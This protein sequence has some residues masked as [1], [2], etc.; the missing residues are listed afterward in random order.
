M[1]TQGTWDADAQISMLAAERNQTIVEIRN[2]LRRRSGKP[3]SVTGGRGTAWGWITITAPKARRDECGNVR[4]TDRVELAE[5]L[6]I[7]QAHTS[8]EVPPQQDFRIEY[9]DRANGRTPS[10]V[11]VPQWD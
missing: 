8:H 4:A 7:D 10:R 6:G 1:A 5:L 3:W 2:A 11:G 9:I